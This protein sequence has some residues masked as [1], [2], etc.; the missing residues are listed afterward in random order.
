MAV[1]VA[2]SLGKA[3]LPGINKWVGLEYDNMPHL[4]KDFMEISSSNRNFE[5]D[6]T[7]AGSGL[8]TQ[9]AEGA[10]IV[11]D[12]M[13]QGFV[14]RY[15]HI[16]YASGIILTREAI[17]DNLYQQLA[18]MQSKALGNAARETREVVCANILNRAFNSSYVGA[19]GL[20][21]CS[22]AH[23]LEKGGTYRNELSTAADLS[24]AS[25]E[26]ACIDIKTQAKDGAN[27][28]IM[29]MP[30][31]LIVPAELGFEAERLLK[32]EL[33]SYTANNAVNAIRSMNMIPDG[34]SVNPYLSDTDAWFIK[35]SVMNGLRMFERRKLA[36]ERDVDFDS[37]NVKFKVSERYSVG[38]TDPRAIFGSPGAA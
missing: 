35:T 32:S 18:Q 19:D 29:A 36:V 26:Q 22:T 30:R 12:D 2:Q 16:V 24:E 15:Q 5:E 20:E 33:Q 10:N 11:Y 3:L 25:L 17:E 27:L 23:L 4:Y 9:K 28:R 13:Q 37:E 7:V 34:V 6:V 38:F 8:L 1:V 31:K 14:K 21:L